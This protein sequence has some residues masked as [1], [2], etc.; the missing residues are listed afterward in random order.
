MNERWIPLT[1]YVK[2]ATGN[3]H[4]REVAA[5]IAAKTGRRHDEIQQRRWRESHL[6][7]I[8]SFRVED[9]LNFVDTLIVEKKPTELKTMVRDPQRDPD[10]D[11]D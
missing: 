5:I 1:A 8:K 11:Q 6:D 2:Y 9:F 7:E 10:Q 3:W 4:D